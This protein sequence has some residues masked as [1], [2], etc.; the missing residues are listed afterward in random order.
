MSDIDVIWTHLYNSGW[1]AQ[2]NR[3]VPIFISKA[4]SMVIRYYFNDSLYRYF[5]NYN[6][7]QKHLEIA[8]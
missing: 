6:Y 1:K 7:F 3:D 8:Y 5:I 4:Y 2:R